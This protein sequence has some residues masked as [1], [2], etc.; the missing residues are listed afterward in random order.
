M[1]LFHMKN[2]SPRILLLLLVFAACKPEEPGPDGTPYKEGVFILNEGNFLA[3]NATLDF[4]NIGN[5]TNYSDIFRTAN[6]APL[7]DVLQSLTVYKERAYIVVNN[8]QKIEVCNV[9]TME[10]EATISGFTSP[11]YLFPVSAKKAY[12]SDLY[13]GTLSIVNLESNSVSGAIP[14]PGWSE[15]MIKLGKEVWI[16]N[17]RQVYIL[18]SDTDQ[19]TDS[20]AIGLGGNSIVE[21]REGKVWVLCGGDFATSAPASLHRI[22]PAS[23]EV[24][25]SLTFA[26]GEYPG[27]LSRSPDSRTIYY[28]AGGGV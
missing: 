20:I 19:L 5:A 11:R 23:R 10:R 14:V 1:M 17:S 22:D 25:L 2:L 18:D 26:A 8:S 13:S 15:R 9:E 12:V 7:G 24:L 27:E 28:V 21:D 16:S 3:A 4:Y 6:S